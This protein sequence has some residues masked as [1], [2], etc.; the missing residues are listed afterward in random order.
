[1]K[2]CVIGTG[3]VGLVGSAIFADWGFDVSGVDIDEKKIKMIEKGKMPIYEPGLK[4]I[5]LENMKAKRLRFTTSLKRGMKDSDVVFICV[6]TPQSRSGA[7]DLSYVWAVAE[8][9]GKN[10]GDGKHRV[11]VTKSTVPVGTNERVKQII[12]ENAPK[13]AKFDVASNPEFLKEGTSVEDM[14]NTDRT[15][16]GVDSKR[17]ERAMRKLYAHLDAPLVMC[18]LRSAEMIKYA[19][20]AFLATKISFINEMA[21]LC[22]KSGADVQQVANGMG[23]DS[24]IGPKFLNAGIGYGGSCFP[25]DVAALRRTSLDFAYDFSLVAGVMEVNDAQWRHFTDKI[26][27]EFGE[28]LEGKTIACLGLAFKSNTDDIRESVAI[29]IVQTL[30]GRGAK[31]R[32]FDPVATPN[33]KE[34]LGKSNM[35][36]AKDSYDAIKGADALCLLTEW[37]EFRGLDLTKVKKLLSKN[38]I[39][40]GRLLLDRKEVEDLGFTYYAVGKRTN[41]YKGKSYQPTAILNGK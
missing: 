39:F 14:R 33:A 13:G 4:E 19:S 5:V 30:R 22:E 37:D 17:G 12:K 9:I 26:L 23:L 11:I 24:R 21:Q 8:E 41:A 29:K 35:Y 10:L 34:V 31:I 20:N 7:A 32:S 25:K 36:Y 15:V 28:N 18:D 6:G 1:M 2:L 27:N 16:V 38:V 40:D 3:Y